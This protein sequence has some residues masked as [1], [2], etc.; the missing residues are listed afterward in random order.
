[1]PIILYRRHLK[2]C[3]VHKTKLKPREKRHFSNCECPIW[4]Y[5]RTAKLLV[6]RQTT[7]T[8]NMTEAEA[9]R[10]ARTAEGKDEKVHG[11]RIN[12]CAKKYL[13]SREHELGEKS[14][15]QYELLLQRL[16]DY[17]AKKGAYFMRELTVDLL[18]T[19]KVEGLPEI[20][21]TSKAKAV[22]KLRA[23]L[24]DAYRREWISEPLVERVKP[25]R[26]TYTQKEPYTEEETTKILAEALKLTGGT[27]GYATQPKTFRLLLELML[28]TGMRVGDATQFN[29]AHL[30][31][32]K[33]LWIYHFQMQKQKRTERPRPM[34]AFITARLK[35]AIDR[36]NWLS[37]D[38]P[39]VFGTSLN[40]SHLG[41][42]VYERMKAI[43][44]RCG[45]PDCRP[46]R[47]RDTFAVRKL[48][49]GV[50]LDDVSR[51]LGH[52]S[53]KVTEMY[54]AKWVGAR[55]QRLESIVAA[56]LREA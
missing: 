8:S 36:C 51:L 35:K 22:E 6:P 28:E 30:A 38:R 24:K 37:K 20:A 56:S 39:F 34:E 23:F 54:Y 16:Q 18:E 44:E 42:E 17:A 50:A 4:M 14:Y 48:T 7:G 5:G 49:N 12:D 46:H 21:D 31:K 41:Q 32:G 15:G 2:T 3:A 13:E 1:V 43:G 9:I 27:H 11:P 33:E 19:F 55:K 26:A 45:V 40:P 52:S 47:L 53:V 10:D 25:H 29:P